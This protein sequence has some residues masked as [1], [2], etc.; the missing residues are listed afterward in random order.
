[1]DNEKETF[2]SYI[3][4]PVL[5]DDKVIYIKILRDIGCLD[6]LLSMI[7]DLYYNPKFDDAHQAYDFIRTNIVHLYK[8]CTENCNDLKE[9]LK[10]LTCLVHGIYELDCLCG[11]DFDINCEEDDD[12]LFEF[13]AQLDLDRQIFKNI[14]GKNY[15]KLYDEVS[16]DLFLKFANLLFMF[17][18]YQAP[19][20]SDPKRAFQ[21]A[22]GQTD[23]FA[24]LLEEL[25]ITEVCIS[26]VYEEIDENKNE[27]D[28]EEDSER[29]RWSI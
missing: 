18:C 23:L 7:K 3:N 13:Y 22:M 2:E 26:E 25:G 21:D 6:Y 27:E 8:I 20:R 5:D 4:L 15:Q 16:K 14:L 24:E 9:D 1:M 28:D 12:K 10:E 29:L 11:I 17:N 19:I